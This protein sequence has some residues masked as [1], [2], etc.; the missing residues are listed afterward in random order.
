MEIN[1]AFHYVLE[2]CASNL[3]R[4]NPV[5]KVDRKYIVKH[6]KIIIIIIIKF[7][8]IMWIDI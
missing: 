2:I 5:N 7:A 3:L 4:A 1:L 8:L 6:N